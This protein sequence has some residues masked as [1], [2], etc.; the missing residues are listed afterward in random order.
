MDFISKIKSE[1]EMKQTANGLFPRNQHCLSRCF[2]GPGLGEARGKNWGQAS[3]C[4]KIRSSG[5]LECSG[6]A[7]NFWGQEISAA[8]RAGRLDFLILVFY[9]H[10]TLKLL[11]PLLPGT[12]IPPPR[13]LSSKDFN[14]HIKWQVRSTPGTQ[15][16]HHPRL[17]RGGPSPSTSVTKLFCTYSGVGLLPGVACT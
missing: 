14:A 17:G 7:G 11:H 2:P 1:R 10:S 3:N 15:H 4:Q 16:P 8:S 12:C 13:A 5:V 6:E 9:E